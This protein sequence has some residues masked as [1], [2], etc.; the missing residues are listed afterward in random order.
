MV[1]Q[2]CVDLNSGAEAEEPAHLFFR[3]PTGSMP[4][5]REALRRRA[6]DIL[7]VGYQ[8]AGD[9]FGQIDQNLHVADTIMGFHQRRHICG[10]APR[11]HVPSRQAF[12]P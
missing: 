8:S 3:E 1:L 9:V 11:P 6:A 2:K 5:Q 10:T 12:G 4:L 7:A